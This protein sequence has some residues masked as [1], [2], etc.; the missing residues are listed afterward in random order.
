MTWSRTRAARWIAG[1]V[2]MQYCWQC[3]LYGN[4]GINS[5]KNKKSWEE[6]VSFFPF[7]MILVLD[8]PS[9]RKFQYLCVLKSIKQHKLRG[10]SVGSTDWVHLW[11]TLWDGITWH[12]TYGM[13]HEIGSGIQV[14][15]ILII[16][17]IWE[18]GIADEKDSWYMQS[19]WPLAAWNTCQVS[20]QLKKSSNIKVI[21]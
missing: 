18:T 3:K 2:Q 14:I 16:A 13:F 9:K 5:I 8:M 7:S 21:T 20:W 12:A 11:Y 4:R 17:A 19:R 1:A 10:C 6:S 15:L